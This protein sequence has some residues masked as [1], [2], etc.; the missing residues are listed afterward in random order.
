MGLGKL[1]YVGDEAYSKCG[2]LVITRCFTHGIANWQNIVEPA[3]TQM[4]GVSGFKG[5]TL[6]RSYC[7]I[8]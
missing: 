8:I 1:G 6:Y 5:T 2:I 3:P 4:F 7:G